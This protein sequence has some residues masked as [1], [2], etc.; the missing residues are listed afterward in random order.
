[1]I[2]LNGMTPVA[3]ALYTASSLSMTWIQGGPLLGVSFILGLEAGRALFVDKLKSF[4]LTI[5]FAISKSKVDEK[6][7]QFYAGHPYYG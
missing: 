1:M 3:C 6:H 2:D 7:A 5:E 4:N